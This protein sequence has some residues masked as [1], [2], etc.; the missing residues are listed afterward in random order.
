MLPSIKTISSDI[1]NEDPWDQV[2]VLLQFF[3]A[4]GCA[5]I[6]AAPIV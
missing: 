1:N 2:N 5:V 6:E 4:R 3:A